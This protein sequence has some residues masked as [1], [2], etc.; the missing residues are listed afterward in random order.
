MAI[1]RQPSVKTQALQNCLAVRVFFAYGSRWLTVDGY[2]KKEF[3]RYETGYYCF[4]CHC[5]EF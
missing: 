3:T 2:K 4:L 1:G 5:P